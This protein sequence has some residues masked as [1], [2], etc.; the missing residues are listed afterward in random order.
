LAV[1]A[2]GRTFDRCCGSAEYNPKWHVWVASTA[3]RWTAELAIGLT[4]LTCQPEV[5]G[6]AWA[7]SAR[8]PHPQGEPQSWSQLRS[9]QP[10]LHAAGLLLFGPVP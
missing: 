2:D 3:D 5:A 9:H 7:I 1:S 10:N 6:N 8:R 4:E